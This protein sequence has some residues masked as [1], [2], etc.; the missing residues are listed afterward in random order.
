MCVSTPVVR[1]PKE[2]IGYVS[3]RDVYLCFVFGMV[4]CWIGFVWF[5]FPSWFLLSASLTSLVVLLVFRLLEDSCSGS[6]KADRS[7][8]WVVCLGNQ[9]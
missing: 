4:F 7:F 1:L 9:V 2:L 6:A 8:L 3:Y 5:L